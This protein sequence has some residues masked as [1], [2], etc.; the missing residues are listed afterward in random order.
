MRL[1]KPFSSPEFLPGNS[2]Y[3]S[4][5]SA[6]AFLQRVISLHSE[7]IRRSHSCLPH[8]SWWLVIGKKP[9]HFLCGTLRLRPAQRTKVPSWDLAVVLEGLCTACFELIEDIPKKFLTLKTVFLFSI[10][11]LK[12]IGGL[13]ALSV[14]PLCL[15]FAPGMVRAFLY[16]RPGMSLRCPLL[17]QG[18]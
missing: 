8:A 4:G 7:G 3:S 15:E 17:H 1:L 2:W 9:T 14:L 11:F 5:V 6:G 13:Q 16:P 10:S 12:R 18:P